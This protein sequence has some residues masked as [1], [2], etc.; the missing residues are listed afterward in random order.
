LT[1]AGRSA[2]TVTV[3]ATANDGSGIYDEITITIS[4]DDLIP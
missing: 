4:E 1:L 3:R 2:G